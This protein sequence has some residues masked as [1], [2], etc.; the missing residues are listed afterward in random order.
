MGGVVWC[1]IETMIAQHLGSGLAY[2]RS[3]S[4]VVQMSSH[5]HKAIYPLRNQLQNETTRLI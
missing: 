3:L 1:D 2:S 4:R 5:A